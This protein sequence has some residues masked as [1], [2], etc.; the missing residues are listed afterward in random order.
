MPQNLE[1]Y[2]FTRKCSEGEN[3]GYYVDLKTIST[4]EYKETLKS[5]DL[6]PSRMILRENID[7]IFKIFKDQKIENVDE[8][9]KTLKSKKKLQDFSRRSGIQED[10]LKILLREINSCRRKPN[11]TKDFP[12]VSEQAALTLEDLGLKNTLQL[13]DRILTRQHRAE[14]A[15]QTGI[16]EGEIARLAKLTDLSRIRWVNHTFAYVLLEAGYDTA[17]KVAEADYQELYEKVKELNEA[18]EIY[19]GQIG[20]HDMKLCVEAAKDVPSE[21][22]Y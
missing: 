12:A 16:T 15:S 21:I 13:F 11:R 22:E 3:I 2:F 6:L 9:Q 10:Y 4:G 17:A 7:E 20:L 19:K 14:L 1:C 5:A 8:L 18:Q